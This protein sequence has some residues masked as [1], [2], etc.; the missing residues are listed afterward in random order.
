[1][2]KPVTKT[3]DGV[4]QPS[5]KT[6][7]RFAAVSSPTP[8]DGARQRFDLAQPLDFLARPPRNVA[9][10]V[11]V[12]AIRRAYAPPYPAISAFTIT[13]ERIGAPGIVSV[14]RLDR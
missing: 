14:V 2:N 13:A 1:M 4:L 10:P 11:M 8:A 12:R 5:Q 7:R 6:L 3:A 9:Q